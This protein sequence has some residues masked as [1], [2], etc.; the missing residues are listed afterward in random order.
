M[1]ERRGSEDELES[2]FLA[3]LIY[4]RGTARY[5][6]TYILSMVS[7]CHGG[8]TSFMLHA[9]S[10]ACLSNYQICHRHWDRP[11]KDPF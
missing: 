6:S 5:R 3:L 8:H 7:G 9:Y 10:S 11:A 2:T 4:M 1:K